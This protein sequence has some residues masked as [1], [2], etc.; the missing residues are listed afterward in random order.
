MD[1]DH[2][3]HVATT[4]ST[5]HVVLPEPITHADIVLPTNHSSIFL[6]GTPVVSSPYF[7]VQ[8]EY[9]GADLI[10]N[11]STINKDVA[12]LHIRQAMIEDLANHH[13]AYPNHPILELSGLIETQAFKNLTYD[14]HHETDI[15]VT[16]AKVDIV[17]GVS[18]WITAFV[19]MELVDDGDS[20]KRSS[21]AD[22]KFTNAF[23]TYGNLHESGLYMTMGQLYLPFGQFTSSMVTNSLPRV[24]GRTRERAIVV[25]YAQP[26]NDG[27]NASVYTFRGDTHKSETPSALN[28][29]INRVGGNLEFNHHG[30]DYSLNFGASVISDMA[31]SCGLQEALFEHAIAFEGVEKHVPA[32]DLRT[33][34]SVDGGWQHNI[35]MSNRFG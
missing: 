9:S 21:R 22:A 7:G 25:G 2:G 15:N 16:D 28:D 27:F 23:V 29:H 14:S 20:L 6:A 32:V 19:E 35:C 11:S 18:P 5:N 3:H 17:A 4:A 8:A 34:V 13:I 33:K 10:V 31:E 26:D 30:Q 1:D 12:L 24:L